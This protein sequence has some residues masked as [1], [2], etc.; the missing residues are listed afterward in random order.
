MSR[1]DMRTSKQRLTRSTIFDRLR[2]FVRDAGM[3][4]A[5]AMN[6]IAHAVANP[7]PRDENESLPG[8]S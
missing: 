7:L 1:V 4:P 2:V 3:T 5:T 8:Y 6:F